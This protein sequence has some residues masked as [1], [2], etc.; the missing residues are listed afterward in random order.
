MH[1]NYA[2]GRMI[3]RSSDSQLMEAVE[4]T[5]FESVRDLVSKGANV[6]Y[7]GP[8]GETPLLKSLMCDDPRICQYLL[9]AGSEANIATANGYG[10]LGFACLQNNFEYVRMLLKYKADINQKTLDGWTPL[11]IASTN[12]SAFFENQEHDFYRNLMEIMYNYAHYHP[13]YNPFHIVNMLLKWGANPT[14]SNMF[15]MTPPYGCIEYG[16]LPDCRNNPGIFHCSGSPG[17]GRKNCSDVCSDFH[18]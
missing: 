11:L 17:Y 16:K 4:N 15:G 7:R 2:F 14:G 3:P 1:L 13:D 8:H 10:P 9:E 12:T 5:N 18:H 6:N